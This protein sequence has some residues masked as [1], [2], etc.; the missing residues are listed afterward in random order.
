MTFFIL[1]TLEE[2][3]VPNANAF[4]A[5]IG[6]ALV[7]HPNWRRSERDLREVRRE[8]TVALIRAIDD[9]D[10]DRATALVETLLTRLRSNGGER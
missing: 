9:D 2:A 5:E 6:A 4:S 1:T 8:I 7:R 10:F 3:S